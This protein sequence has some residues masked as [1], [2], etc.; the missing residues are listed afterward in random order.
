MN[1]IYA[2]ILT[3]FFFAENQEIYR[4]PTLSPDGS[5][6][7]FTYQGDIWTAS[8]SGGKATRLTIHEAYDSRPQWSP[9]GK[10]LLFSSLR[11]GNNDLYS[12]D[13]NGKNLQRHTYHSASDVDGNWIDNKQISFSSRRNFVAVEREYEFHKLD[14][15][16]GTPERYMNSLGSDG[17]F[18]TNHDLM[19][20]V[21]GGCRIERETYKGPANRDIWVYDPEDGNYIQIT[22]FDGQDVL[23][24]WGAQ[25]DLFYLSAKN[26]KY[27]IYKTILDDDNKPGESTAITSFTD[28]GIRNYDVAANG[29]SLIYVKGI[30]IYTYDIASGNTKKIVFDVPADYRFDPIKHESFTSG[31][32]DYAISPD[33]KYIAFSAK[34]DLFFTEN[35]K[36][37]SLTINP[38]SQSSRETQVDW[39]NDETALFLSDRNGTF[40]LFKISSIDTS[41]K[42][43]F[44]SFK[45]KIEPVYESS[46]EVLSFTLSPDRKKVSILSEPGKLMIADIDSTGNLSNQNILHYSW[47]ATEDLAWSPDSEWIAFSRPDLDFNEEIFI[48]KADGSTEPINVSMHPRGDYSP[49][50]SSDG[51]KLG[52]LSIRN[53]GDA[54]IWFAWLSNKDWEKTNNDWEQLPESSKKEKKDSIMKVHIDIEN[55]HERLV[56]VTSLAGNEGDLM[57]DG[58]GDLF[59][60]STNNSGRQ[61]SGGKSEY[62]KVKWDGDDLSTLLKDGRVSNVQ[63]DKKGKDIYFTKSGG[64]NTA[65]IA[66]GKDEKRPFK[67]KM[68]INT[69]E[70]RAQVFDEA[71]RTINDRFYDPK[72]HGQNWDAL[73]AK[74]E[75]WAMAASTHNDFQMLFNEMLGQVNASH[76]GLR[77]SGPEETQRETTGLIGVELENVPNG[78]KITAIVPDSP[79]DREDSKLNVGDIIISVNNN[80]ISETESR[81]FYALVNQT[82]NDRI[83][84]E[85]VSSNGTPRDVIIRPV[86]SLSTQRYEAWINERKRLTEKYSNGKLG[87]IHIR[88]MNWPS[89][90]RFERELMASGYGKEGIVIDVRYNGGGWTTD[91]VMAVL[92][93]R[94]HSYT[95][96]RGATDDLSRDHQDYKNNYPFGERLPL[97]AL[98]KPSVALCNEAS[99][100][101]AEIFSHAY[102]T[103]GH[104]KLV[105]QPTFGAVI[106]TGGRGLMD[107]SFVRVPFRAWY[108]KATGEN[109][110]WG[111]AVPDYLVENNPESEFKNE[112]EQL[113]KAVDVLLDQIR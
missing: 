25:K 29:K 59:L 45:W 16:G 106:S 14:T 83:L 17:N 28:Q 34:G 100:S 40:N 111:P 11:N 18:S 104:G 4:Y 75:P 58:E 3:Q 81:N 110:E 22:D 108:V 99:Y 33:E 95:V 47:A 43:I 79:A 64:L 98:T 2:L 5:E 23:P 24:E 38:L 15:E 71:W 107:G 53:N 62:M 26:G 102:K 84:L 113:K 37:K 30:D 9:N 74:Y 66:S 69:M 32:S 97:S 76:M 52:F 55:I 36:E 42:A 105:G 56:Q 91:M 112:D 46:D 6:I 19:A 31:I 7:A 101:N 41:E 50:W 63:L 13:T 68:D 48:Q 109:M 82:A 77:G 94:Q 39:L 27:N 103:L 96:P 35:D 85:V 61:G 1:F 49:V 10:K 70:Y 54:D 73:R 92:N 90:E 8:S 89:F 60:F 87:Y 67:A 88:G 12:I 44:W 86:S 65:N 78:V 80:S 20:Y 51:S 21:R 72:F 93:V 57:I